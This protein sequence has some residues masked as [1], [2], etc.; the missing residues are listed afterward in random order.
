MRRICSLPRGTANAT[1]FNEPII[2]RKSVICQV[3][4]CSKTSIRVRK[5]TILSSGMAM[6]LLRGDQ[7]IPMYLA[8]TNGNNSDFLAEIIQPNFSNSE[9]TICTWCNNNSG[10]D[11]AINK[12]SK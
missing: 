3:L 1:K 9:T 2:E 5:E 4:R 10:E 8:V 11:A 12:S 6:K 7:E